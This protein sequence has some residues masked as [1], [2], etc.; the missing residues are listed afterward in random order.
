MHRR[1]RRQFRRAAMRLATLVVLVSGVA[2]ALGELVD[3]KRAG[4]SLISVH[5]AVATPP[6]TFGSL[7]PEAIWKFEIDHKDGAR[8]SVPAPRATIAMILEADG[9]VIEPGHGGNRSPFGFRLGSN[10]V[11]DLAEPEGRLI[12]EASTRPDPAAA[13][14]T[15]LKRGEIA[16]I[17]VRLPSTG[18]TAAR[19]KL[20]GGPMVAVVIDDLGHN[21]AHA[22]R[23]MNLPEPATMAFLPYPDPTPRLAREAVNAG[24]EVILHMP[25]EP[26]GD[27]DPGPK[28]LMVELPVHELLDRVKWALDRVPGAVGVNNHMGSRFTN[29]AVVMGVVLEQLKERQLFFVDS[30][31]APRTVVSD[32]AA[33]VALPSAARDV[34]IDHVPTRRSI[35]AQLARAEQRARQLGSAIAIGH[36]GEDTLDALEKWMP[37][38]ARRGIRFVPVSEVVAHRLCTH[39]T[40]GC[41]NPEQYL[42]QALSELKRPE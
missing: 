7:A 37:E 38:A 36:P 32:V 33:A 34:F 30:V 5:H 18:A 27:A 26:Q 16:A 40:E 20:A 17:P 12:W 13:A 42:A 19:G 15:D 31:T 8:A 29:D 10:A 2:W 21:P 14:V 35:D 28:A 39:S 6:P 3:E 23:V 11:P 41:S 4:A 25:M 24:R 9:S 1:R 22:A